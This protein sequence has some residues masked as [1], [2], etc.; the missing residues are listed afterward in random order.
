MNI[1]IDYLWSHKC[2][3]KWDQYTLVALVI[4]VI[5]LLILAGISIAQLTGNGLFEKAKLSKEVSKN[6]QDDE[7]DKIADYSN[8]IEDYIDATRTNPSANASVFLNTN[9]IIQATTNLSDGSTYTATEDCAV[10]YVIRNDN[11]G[12]GVYVSIDNVCVY[13]IYDNTFYQLANMSYLKKGQTIKFSK[14]TTW[15]TSTVNYTVYG[16]F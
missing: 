10:I 7:E 15:P 14:D 2:P 6:A 8:K 5:I 16:L 12:A 13:H 11:N 1:E 9:K 3:K 4:T